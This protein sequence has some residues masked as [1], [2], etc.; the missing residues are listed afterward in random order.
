LH[1][2]K[3]AINNIVE[4]P[5]DKAEYSVFDFETTGT[6]A[7][8]D[9]V[10]EIGIVKVKN[11]KIV[12]TFQSYINPG[13]QIPYYITQITGITNED[14]NDAPYFDELFNTIIEFFGTSVIVAHNLNFDLSFLRKECSEASKEF[15]FN[16]AIC[17]VRLAKRVY[18]QFT[19][20][21]LGN[22]TKTLKIKHR[23]VHR[24]L[25]DASATAKILIKMFKQLRED[26]DI[27]TVSDL[28]HFQNLPSGSPSR[29]IKKKLADHYSSVPNNPGIYFF[30]DGKGNVIYVGKAKS[31]KKRVSNY[32]QSNTPRKTRKII[33]KAHS[34]DFHVTNTELIALISEA[35]LIKQ[36]NPRLNTLLKKFSRSY[37]IRIKR[38]D[39]APKVEAATNFE[40]DGNDYYGPY[41]NRDTTKSLIDII[42]KTFALR[43]CTDIEFNKKKKCYLADI[44]RCLAPCVNQGY[45]EKYNYELQKVNDFLCGN[46]Q[47]AVDRL[48]A[49]MK[50]LSE[51]KK[52]EEAAQIRDTINSLFMQLNKSS[53]LAEPINKAN[54]LIEISGFE[55]NDYLLLLEGRVF[56]KNYTF[57]KN[58]FDDALDHY[59]QGSIDLFK[60]LTDKDLERLKISLAWL[61][62]NKTR[63]KIHYLSNFNSLEELGKAFIFTKEE[64]NNFTTEF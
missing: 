31:L 15:P 29:L 9:K 41:S 1:S 5:F 52:F 14:V 34:L 46:N 59:F 16:P 58:T 27:E 7:R 28:V 22:L 32:F 49:K 43:E 2:K 38:D 55:T 48:L 18:P 57:E 3:R 24:G 40:F 20:R 42:D 10:I 33:Q 17:T 21:S 30:K 36:H 37:F 56:I 64:F 61:V 60:K 44:E 53:I 23:D 47:S 6:S 35:E 63:I 51:R 19:S 8:M 12:D 45:E 25:G 26:F 54:V 62:K 50:D 11:G 13:R 4:L 39:T